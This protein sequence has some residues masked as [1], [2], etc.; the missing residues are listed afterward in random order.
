M[1]GAFIGP[2]TIDRFGR[3]FNIMMC[4]VPFVGGWTMVAGAK[5]L[6]LFYLGRFVVGIGLGAISLTVPVSAKLYSVTKNDYYNQVSKFMFSSIRLND[7]IS[8]DIKKLTDSC[9]RTL[10]PYVIG[11][12]L[13]LLLIEQKRFPVVEPDYFCWSRPKNQYIQKLHATV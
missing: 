8:R 11:L 5:A 10:V 9:Q 1:L 4:S 6:P 12:Y 7:R 2:Y 3:K 13:F